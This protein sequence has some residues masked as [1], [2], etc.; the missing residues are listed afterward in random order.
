M[1]EG[2]AGE[3]G[4]DRARDSSG[5]GYRGVITGRKVLVAG[6]ELGL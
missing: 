5:K 1:G 6:S 2:R 4:Y 3:E